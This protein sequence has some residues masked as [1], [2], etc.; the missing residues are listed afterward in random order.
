MLGVKINAPG[1]NSTLDDFNVHIWP[2]Q[3]EALCG[4]WNYLLTPYIIDSPCPFCQEKV[5]ELYV[6]A[7]SP[8]KSYTV[9]HLVDLLNTYRTGKDILRQPFLHFRTGA[10]IA[11]VNQWIIKTL[12]AD[13]VSVI[14]P[15]I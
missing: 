15:W 9:R 11:E 3:Q 2:T 1:A 8:N 5:Y 6:R 12:D 13:P 7:M 4:A 14:M 10:E